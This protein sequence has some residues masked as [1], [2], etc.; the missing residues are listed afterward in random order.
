MTQTS[1]DIPSAVGDQPPRAL[2]LDIMDTVVV[3]PFFDDDLGAHFGLDRETLFARMTPDI[4]LAFERG[5]LTPDTY[6]ARFF[7]DGSGVDGAALEA[8]MAS[9]YRWVPG[10]EALLAELQTAGVGLYA[11]S[12]YPVWWQLIEARLGVGRYVGW[13]F[14]SCMTGVRKPA[15]RAYLGP[16]ETLALSPAACLFIDDRQS[17]C[18]AARAVGM[19]AHRFE[20]ADALRLALRSTGI[21]V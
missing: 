8:W 3:D 15:P 21:A 4:W 5:E 1:P 9:R 11:L 19:P 2:L 17:N 6:Y 13:R 7:R 12:N 20:S 18:D 10:M 14:V 16:A